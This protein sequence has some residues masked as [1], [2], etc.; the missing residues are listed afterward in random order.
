MAGENVGLSAYNNPYANYLNYGM[1]NDDV[2]AN[3]HFNEI[4]QTGRVPGMTETTG[5]PAFRGHQETDTFEKSG[6][7]GLAEGA[8]ITVAGAGAG[9]ASGYFL[10][11]N[12]IKNHENKILNPAFY[13]TI[14]KAD[15]EKKIKTTIEATKQTKGYNLAQLA[16]VEKF[17]DL[18]DE[19]KQFLKAN[20]LDK[21]TPAEAK[22]LLE[23][24]GKKVEDYNLDNIAK[25]V[26]ENFK[27]AA[28]HSNVLAKA[29]AT[30]ELAPLSADTESIKKL[31]L[32]NKELYGLTGT[33]EEIAKQIDDIITNGR[34]KVALAGINTT[35][36]LKNFV[37]QNKE[38][39][40]IKGSEEE[41]AK[42]IDELVAKG[43]NGVIDEAATIVSKS[44][45][46]V[47]VKNQNIFSHIDAKGKLAEDAPESIK[48]LFKDF[49]WQQAKKFGKWGAAIAGGVAVLAAMFGGSSQPTT[50]A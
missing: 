11:G 1:Q 10:L 32:Q 17:D 22:A 36:E 15:I 21:K 18:S 39:F 30:K 48:Q 2:M 33:E 24:A 34:K 45:N 42:Q 25:K 29:N 7:I 26:R 16:S 46:Y 27:G 19:V 43:K 47:K 4:A 38:F 5:S 49:K 23:Q 35:E 3:L 6:G 20:G 37:T 31:F 12:P 8:A 28:Y 13:Q 50:K 40:G 41:V 9:A 14:D 44:E